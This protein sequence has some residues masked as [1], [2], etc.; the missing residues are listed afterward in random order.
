M[1]KTKEKEKEKEKPPVRKR[2]PVIK[3]MS[4]P[5]R[6]QIETHWPKAQAHWSRFLLLSQPLNAAGERDIAKIDLSTRQVYLNGD[7]IEQKQLLD[8]LEGILAHEI[9]HHVRYPGSLVTHARLRMLEK[10]LLPMEDYSVVNLFTDLLINE[11]LGHALRNQLMRVYQAFQAEVK[12]KQDPAF[13]FYLSIYEELWQLEPGVLMGPGRPEFE[14]RFPS[15]RADAQLVAQNL[16]NLGPNL[17]T[18]FIYFVS[19]ISRYIEPLQGELPI[20]ADPY[21]CGCGEPSPEDWADALHPSPRELEAVKKALES[22]WIEQETA[23]R[24]LG[25]EALERRIAGLPGQNQANAE[26]VPEVM[27]AY[28]RL[29]AERLLFTPPP[30]QTFGDAL[31]PT[32]LDEWEAGEPVALIDWLSTLRLRGVELGGVQPLRRERIS[33]VEGLD[34]PL[35]QPRVEIYLDVSGSMPDPRRSLN[36]MTL[37][38]QILCLGAVRAGGWIRALLYSSDSVAYWQWCRSETEISRFMM[39][40]IGS[41][42]HFPFNKL[43][44]S[45]RECRDSQPTRVVISDTDFD[46]NYQSDPKNAAIFADAAAVSAPLVLLLHSPRPERVSLYETKGAKVVAVPDLEDFP[47]VAAQL[48][49]ALFLE[50]NRVAP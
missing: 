49:Q 12:W 25:P 4:A 38:A 5:L 40:Y 50:G 21:Q 1:S 17:F 23:E 33:D 10:S 42:T 2:E 20:S 19:I 8:C 13:L 47:R 16:F 9:G 46:H 36:A 3:E 30:R 29:Q 28:Y 15:A 37:A 27:A 32:T 24:V 34:V 44:D 26:A 22:G 14:R 48:A 43:S 18:Q 7:E 39:H 41:G 6:E 31:V 11:S 45:V 35:W